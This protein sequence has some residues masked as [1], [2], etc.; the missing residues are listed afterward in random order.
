MNVKD[1]KN[2]KNFSAFYGEFSIFETKDE[3]VGLINRQ[4][5][6]VY[7]AGKFDLASHLQNGVFFFQTICDKDNKCIEMYFDAKLGK[8]VPAPAIE[9][10]QEPE[11]P[12]QAK[13]FEDIRWCADNRVAFKDGDLY[14]VMDEKGNVIVPP[15]YDFIS[16]ASLAAHRNRISV[17]KDGKNG[18]IDLEGNVVIPFEHP[19]VGYQQKLHLHKFRTQEKKWGYMDEKGQVVIPAI[20]DAIDARETHGLD[21]IAVTKDGRC[22]FINAKQEEVK[23]F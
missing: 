12:E 10:I 9:R 6:V 22:Y 19:Y 4:G 15:T 8:E 18:Y 3:K 11:F 17:K 23:V 5:E 13:K 21:E 14:G 2:L 16:I 1:I 20:Y 7:P